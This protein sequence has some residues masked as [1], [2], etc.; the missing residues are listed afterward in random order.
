MFK[1]KPTCFF[2]FETKQKKK[3]LFFTHLLH[4]PNVVHF[5]Y[6]AFL[7]M[8]EYL[9]L[10]S[11]SERMNH[12]VTIWKKSIWKDW[13]KLNYQIQV[14]SL[15]EYRQDQ[16]YDS[17]CF[18]RSHFLHYIYYED[19][20]DHHSGCEVREIILNWDFNCI[21]EK[22]LVSSLT[23]M[24]V[25]PFETRFQKTKFGFWMMGYNVKQDSNFNQ[26]KIS[27]FERREEEKIWNKKLHLIYHGFP[28]FFQQKNKALV[29]NWE[30]NEFT[31]YIFQDHSSI[32]HIQIQTYL[33]AQSQI[34]Y[35]SNLQKWI[36]T[37]N[38]HRL[39]RWDTWFE[40]DLVVIRTSR[41]EIK[42]FLFARNKKWI[43][44]DGQYYKIKKILP[45]KRIIVYYSFTKLLKI[46][47]ITQNGIVAHN[48]YHSP[49]Y[50]F[51]DPFFMY[52]PFFV[53]TCLLSFNILVVVFFNVSNQL[54]LTLTDLSDL[55][56]Y[57]KQT[58]LGPKSLVSFKPQIRN[59]Y[60]IQSC[61]IVHLRSEDK[62]DFVKFTAISPTDQKCYC[63]S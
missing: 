36:S 8:Y 19:Y 57:K 60:Y 46:W 51:Y 13:M 31:C 47:F 5:E 14:R 32:P 55:S 6:F 29:W 33:E 52:D 50:I 62:S 35:L 53:S 34:P 37:Q 59:V 49:P 42:I 54:E 38:F 12:L 44:Q 2:F 4:L 45:N 24:D 1:S 28:F 48:M 20:E 63:I 17:I 56:G 41:P 15:G 10:G 43:I 61:F 23:W 40:D 25:Y 58:Y 22:I 39:Y 18:F 11:V 27:Y 26:W 7:T 3:M 21:Q 30:K 9:D 16:G